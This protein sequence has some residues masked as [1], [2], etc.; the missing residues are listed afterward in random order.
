M[1]KEHYPL[2]K[3]LQLFDVKSSSYYDR[4]KKA[5]KPADKYQILRRQIVVQFN[6]SQG[7][8]GQRTLQHMLSHGATYSSR[9]LIRKIM[10]EEGLRSSQTRKHRYPKGGEESLISPNLLKRRFDVTAINRWWCGD[11]TYIWTQA[12]WC[13]LAVVLDLMSRRVVG[14][15]LSKSPDTQL[16]MKAFNQAFEARRKPLN[17]VF[18]SDQGCHYTSY[19]FR[20]TLKN[21]GVLQSM[22]RRGN[23][24][25][26]SPMERFFRAFKTERMPRLGYESFDDAVLDVSSYIDGY[27]NNV[28]PHTHNNGLP[29]ITAEKRQVII[30]P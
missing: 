2:N 27:Y 23:C 17:L 9:Y 28:R 4:L 1:L 13:Y 21:N 24:W 29:P 18:H 26:N 8:A 14:Y 25:D 10:K 30:N 12:G 3:L 19:Q 5:V 22:S 7:S 11:V 6:K 16:T 20:D 15:A